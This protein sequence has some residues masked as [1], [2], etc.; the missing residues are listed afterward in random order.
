MVI[1]DCQPSTTS[2]ESIDFLHKSGKGEGGK[3]KGFVLS[4][5]P[6]TFSLFPT[7]AKVFFARGL[8]C[9]FYVKQLRSLK[10][11]SNNLDMEFYNQIKI[12]SLIFNHLELGVKGFLCKLWCKSFRDLFHSPW[13]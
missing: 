10:L 1:V 4:P 13:V 8:M 9:N 5:S 3:G 2:S 11:A 7:L 6:L 12:K